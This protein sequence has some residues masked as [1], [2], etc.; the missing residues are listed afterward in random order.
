MPNNFKR[1]ISVALSFLMLTS[2]T[3]SVSAAGIESSNSSYISPIKSVVA[4]DYAANDVFMKPF[5]AEVSSVPEP[6]KNIETKNLQ[7]K[8]LATTDTGTCGT[9]VTY[10]FDGETLTISGSGAMF[11]YTSNSVPWNDYKDSIKSVVIKNSVQT[12]GE[13]AFRSCSSLKSVT[14]PD[15]VQLI[16]TSAFYGCSGLTSV[17]IPNSVQT[18]GESAF[19]SC[20]SLTSITI[21]DSVTSIGERAFDGCSSLTTVAIPD[22]VQSIG[23]SAFMSCSSLASV[24]IGNGVQSIG[25]YAFYGCSGLQSIN[26]SGGNANYKSENGVLFSKDG[27]ALILYPARKT[28]TSYSIPDNVQTIESYAFYKCSSLTSITIGNGVQ[29]IGASAFSNCS[30]LTSVT[31]GNGVTSIGARTFY[32]CSSLTSVTYNG[33]SEPTN[34]TTVFEGCTSLTSVNVPTNY[35]GDTFCGMPVNK[36]I[37]LISSKDDFVTFMTTPAYWGN[38]QKVTLTCDLDMQNETFDYIE[39]FSGQFDGGDHTIS[40]LSFKCFVKTNN[41]KISNINF[42]GGKLINDSSIRGGFA[43]TNEE[44]GV[45]DNCSIDMNSEDANIKAGFVYENKGTITN[46]ETTLSVKSNN[47]G[48]GGFVWYNKGEINSCIATGNANG[49]VVVGGFVGWNN[50]GTI[51][52]CNATGTVNG[53]DFIGGFAGF[54]RGIITYCVATGDVTGNYNVGGFSG[55]NRGIITNCDAEGNIKGNGNVG[56]FV[57]WNNFY[58]DNGITN[59]KAKGNVIGNLLVGGF[60]GFNCGIITECNATGKVNGENITLDSFAG[61]NSGEITDCKID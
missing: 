16:G 25:S 21:P 41:G 58:F 47:F 13:S 48:V 18:I 24:T 59:C 49:K 39:T 9:N 31:I 51:T 52:N 32:R 19:R 26:V 6:S 55:Y 11:N 35:E 42:N 10:T 50:N 17:T 2:V 38:N 45:I 12:I 3:P 30:N 22:S 29:S 54:S 53:A 56:G 33:I 46:S 14:I 60:T 28:D 20:S 40:N 43:V 27:A 36:I 34:S 8:I 7:R 15:S 44:G 57:G 4:P 1:A 5:E 23:S 61:K 37:F